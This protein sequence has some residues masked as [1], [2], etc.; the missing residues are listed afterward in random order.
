MVE[1]E[2]WPN[3]LALLAGRGTPVLAVGARASERSAARWRLLPRL[4]RQVLQTIRFLSAQDEASAAR[5]LAAGLPRAALGPVLDLKALAGG[6]EM[7][8]L[9]ADLAGA[10]D[11]GATLLAASTHDGE[12]ALVLAAFARQYPQG[13]WKRLIL[14]PRHPRRAASVGRQIAAAGLAHRC[15]SAGQ[16]PDDAPVY[17]ADTLGEMDLWYRLAALTFVGGSLVARGGHT[18]HEPAR[19]AS[20]ILHGPHVDNFAETYRALDAAGGAGVVAD[21]ETL[22]AALA[23]LGEAEARVAMTER[24]RVVLDAPERVPLDRL[25]AALDDALGLQS[26]E[27]RA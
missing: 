24:A 25:L 8:E 16:T 22:G 19:Y 27:T 9:P 17:L 20:A 15:R 4:V 11:R 26:R 6:A 5:F 3:R 23:D 2:L 21:A 12:E 10:F 14:A 7:A 1:N 13:H 18:P